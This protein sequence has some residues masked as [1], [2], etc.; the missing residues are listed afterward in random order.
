[1]STT[2]YTDDHEWVRLDSDDTAVFGI[3]DYAQQQLGDIVFVELPSTGESFEAG[4]E[5]AVVESVKTAADVKIPAAGTITEVN[6]ELEDSP[7]LVN[8][9]PMED[10]WFCK[11]QLSDPT[12]INSLKSEDE[13]QIYTA[14][15]E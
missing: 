7:E 6:E 11:I 12:E 5:V 4:A 10:G 8:T 13:Y 1:M 14:A 3:T 9:S 15:F 2:R